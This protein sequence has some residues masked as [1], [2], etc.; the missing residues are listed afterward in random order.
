[1]KIAK[2]QRPKV[3]TKQMLVMTTPQDHEFIRSVSEKNHISM[4]DLI[5]NL[6]ND[7]KEKEGFT[8]N[9][10]VPENQIALF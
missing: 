10:E 9:N 7:Y 3:L 6:I 4:G 5:R 1:M 2:H 8:N